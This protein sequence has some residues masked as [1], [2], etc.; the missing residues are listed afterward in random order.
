MKKILKYKDYL[1]E[2]TDAS[3]LAKDIFIPIIDE[4]GDKFE[5]TFARFKSGS[6]ISV[7]WRVYLKP[8]YVEDR[9][10]IMKYDVFT[11]DLFYKIQAK[12]DEM[13]YDITE[14]LKRYKNI[15]V[16]KTDLYY[17]ETDSYFPEKVLVIGTIGFNKI[18]E[19][20]ETDM[21]YPIMKD[22]FVSIED[23][24]DDI[25]DFEY[26]EINMNKSC[27][28][29]YLKNDMFK[30]YSNG[31][32]MIKKDECSEFVDVCFDLDKYIYGELSKYENKIKYEETDYYNKY[33]NIVLKESPIIHGRLTLKKNI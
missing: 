31:G 15:D 11:T 21:M 3:E 12:L 19:S 16:R 4:W 27:F 28:T 1:K 8:E 2:G 32:I 9:Y 22:I 10:F 7:E 14:E 17:K 24:F 33:T 5:F 23:E 6:G 13:M 18:Y 30:K 25:F 20:I 29:I 26:T